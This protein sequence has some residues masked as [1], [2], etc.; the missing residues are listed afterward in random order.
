MLP[1]RPC[2]DPNLLRRELRINLHPGHNARNGAEPR[3]K[4][5]VPASTARFVDLHSATSS[6]DELLSMAAD[7]IARVGSFD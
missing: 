6:V 4:P 5:A 1:S 2:R 7:V 3:L